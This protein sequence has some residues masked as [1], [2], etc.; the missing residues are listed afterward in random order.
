MEA[1]SVNNINW[2]AYLDGSLSDAAREVANKLLADDPVART[3][4]ENL[5]GFIAQIRESGLMEEVPLHRL[6]SQLQTVQ[7]K[8]KLLSWSWKPLLAAAACA[9]IAFA[10]FRPNPA[11]NNHILTSNFNEASSWVKETTGIGYPNLK[12]AGATLVASERAKNSGCFCMKMGQKMVHLRFSKDSTATK[13]FEKCI[14][15]GCDFLKRP[16]CAAFQ[17]SGGITWMVECQ[18]RF[19]SD[20]VNIKTAF[21]REIALSSV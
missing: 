8:H 9:A 11:T 5:K 7:P 16:G 2:H 1:T 3:N 12:L 10:I 6:Q 21:T 13:G 18:S 19:E 20:P 17:C 14:V 4:L 15:D